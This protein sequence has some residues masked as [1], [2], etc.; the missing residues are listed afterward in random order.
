MQKILIITLS[1]LALIG[2]GIA[3][4]ILF[5]TKNPIIDIGVMPSSDI[6]KIEETVV[7]PLT[8]YQEMRANIEQDNSKNIA[9]YNAA[10]QAKNPELCNTITAEDKKI[11]CHDMIISAEAKTT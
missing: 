1:F 2:A 8:P 7:A 9:S 6:P 4:Y 3:T 5:L 11:E 10:M